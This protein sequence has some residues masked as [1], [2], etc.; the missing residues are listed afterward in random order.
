MKEHR[1]KLSRVQ[2][3]RANADREEKK[4]RASCAHQ[5]K[6]DKIIVQLVSDISNDPNVSPTAVVCPECGE[7]FDL[8]QYAAAD[9]SQAVSVLHDVIQQIRLYSKQSSDRD[10]NILL[11]KLDADNQEIPNLYKRVVDTY[12][13]GGNRGRNNRNKDRNKTQSSFGSFGNATTTFIG[14]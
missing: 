2:E 7:R 1:Q 3:M 6:N 9:V 5:N 12:N 11:G 13:R 4:I 14:R 8:Q 10:N